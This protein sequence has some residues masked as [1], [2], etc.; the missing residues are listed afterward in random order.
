MLS[1][2]LALRLAQHLMAAWEAARQPQPSLDNAWQRIESRFDRAREV[3]EH[4][5]FAIERR[6]AAST[7]S[8]SSDL[9]YHLGELARMLG[10][11]R[12]ELAAGRREVAPLGSWLADVRQLEDEFAGIEVKW[13]EKVVRAVTEPITLGEVE[14]GPF[15]IDFHWDHLGSAKGVDCFDIEALEPNPAQGRDDVVHP[16]VR[17]N[18]LCAGE[19]M[20]PLERALEQGRFPEAFLLIRAVLTTYNRSSPYVALDLWDGT[21]CSD[22]GRRVDDEDRY[23]CEGCDNDSCDRCS[24]SCARC[25]SSRCSNCLEDCAVCDAGC[26]SGCLETTADERRVCASCF[27][28]C[29]ECGRRLPK[30]ELTDSLCP[31]CQPSEEEP[32]DDDDVQGVIHAGVEIAR[33]PEEADLLPPGLAQAED[34]FTY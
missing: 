33:F 3:R 19:A 16:H 4:L 32:D 28:L 18:D 30:D 22:C 2:K 10:S 17:D 8:L 27:A 12:E 15:A 29:S 26:C 5:E 31:D 14:L 9:K 6:F 24:G 1:T 34:V 23:G 11:L 25:M 20:V 7:Q 13:K 21:P